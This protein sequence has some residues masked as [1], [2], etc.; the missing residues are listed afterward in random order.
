MLFIELTQDPE[1]QLALPLPY[2]APCARDKRKLNAHVRIARCHA[3]TRRR[4]QSRASYG[5]R[6]TFLLGRSRQLADLRTLIRAFSVFFD[7]INLAEQQARVRAL[8]ARRAPFGAP[9]AH[10]QRSDRA[11]LLAAFSGAGPRFRRKAGVRRKLSLSIW[12][13]RLL[14]ESTAAL[15]AAPKRVLSPSPLLQ[16]CP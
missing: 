13:L 10:L 7:L 14:R 4:L 15:C 9:H 6:R 12:L 8:R 16:A 1:S 11:C 3:L 5:S 2:G